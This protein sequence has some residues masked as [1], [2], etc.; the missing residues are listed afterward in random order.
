MDKLFNPDQNAVEWNINGTNEYEYVNTK[1][2]AVV[3]EN[4]D[5]ST[6]DQVVGKRIIGNLKGPLPKISDISRNDP[7]SAVFGMSI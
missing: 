6:S 5:L 1:I 4:G 7:H 2:T 3:Y